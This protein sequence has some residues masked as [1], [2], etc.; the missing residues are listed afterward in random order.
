MRA[1]TDLRAALAA[2]IA[3]WGMLSSGAD[4]AEAPTATRVGTM[5]DSL[6]NRWILNSVGQLE[7]GSLPIRRGMVLNLQIDG[8]SFAFNPTSTNSKSEKAKAPPDEPIPD[9]LKNDARFTFRFPEDTGML[10]T[11]Y[12]RLDTARRGVRFI[13]VLKNTGT[14]S[15]SVV[16]RYVQEMDVNN[17]D[18]FQGAATDRGVVLSQENPAFSDDTSGVILQFSPELSPAM[19]M[20]VFGKSRDTWTEERRLDSYQLKLE[21]STTLEAGQ[22]AIFIHWIGSKRPQE[23]GKAEKAFERFITEGHLI[24]T[25]MPASWNADVINFTPEALSP[26][27]ARKEGPRLVMLEKLCKRLKMQPGSADLL[28][29]EPGSLVEGDFTAGKVSLLREGAP[30]SVPTANIAAIS[31]GAGKG[32]IHRLFL[33]DGSVLNGQVNWEA[34]VFKSKSVGQVALNADS[35]DHLVLRQTSSPNAPTPS[36]GLIITQGGEALRILNLPAPPLSVLTAMGEIDLPWGEIATLGE[37]GPT[38][39]SFAITLKDGSR[40]ACLPRLSS[41]AFALSGDLKLHA[42][43]SIRLF[44]AE[45]QDQESMLS[46]E[47]EEMETKPASGW[48]ALAQGTF[49]AGRPA[50]GELAIEAGGGITR[51]QS[52]ELVSARRQTSAPSTPGAAVTFDIELSTGLK[53]RGKFLS[54]TLPWRQGSRVLNLPW[55]QITELEILKAAP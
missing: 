15:R 9:E 52:A 7:R 46:A 41:V 37:S 3:A 48:C 39:P 8:R 33:R 13:D 18:H 27:A 26:I 14:S 55:S 11:R 1:A 31:G 43:D 35:L 45:E 4:A 30:V 54:P 21:R 50:D 47:S 49:W 34:A 25:G 16:L 44:I 28:L 22:R 24:D 23:K 6:E 32:R 42:S 51:F 40:I 5:T 10:W 19:P 2:G 36:A 20:F 12:V 53:L 38:D 29:L 17:S